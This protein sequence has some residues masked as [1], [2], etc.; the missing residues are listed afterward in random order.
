MRESAD[1]LFAGKSWRGRLKVRGSE[2]PP[3]FGRAS[4]HSGVGLFCHAT[5]WRDRPPC[6]EPPLIPKNS[7]TSACVFC[8]SARQRTTVGWRPPRTITRQN[9]KIHR[10]RRGGFPLP[11]LRRRDGRHMRIQGP[12]LPAELRREADMEEAVRRALREEDDVRGCLFSGG[13]FWCKIKEK[14]RAVRALV[15]GAQLPLRTWRGNF[16]PSRGR[17][18]PPGYPHLHRGWH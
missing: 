6:C 17:K 2:Q 11:H 7:L 4:A 15:P 5:A 18:S 1:I 3:I 10:L 14:Q 16:F 13:A 9:G 8:H 12:V